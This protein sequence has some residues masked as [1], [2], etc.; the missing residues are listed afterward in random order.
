MILTNPIITNPVILINLLFIC[1]DM[2][3]GLLGTSV[4][5]GFIYYSPSCYTYNSC[6]E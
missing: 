6:G 5:I 1:Y 3:N 4:K 2:Y